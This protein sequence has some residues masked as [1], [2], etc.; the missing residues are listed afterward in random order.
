MIQSETIYPDAG[1]TD[2][3]RDAL[4]A[5]F[6]EREQLLFER[7]WGRDEYGRKFEE[8]YLKEVQK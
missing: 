5:L 3:Q 4:L 2:K 1:L 7:M 6:L 8:F